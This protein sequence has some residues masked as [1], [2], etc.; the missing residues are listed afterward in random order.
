MF[1]EYQGKQPYTIPFRVVYFP[2]FPADMLD[3]IKNRR[4]QHYSKKEDKERKKPSSRMTKKD[5]YIH[6]FRDD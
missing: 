3:I 2:C 1:K 6:T 5:T 4:L